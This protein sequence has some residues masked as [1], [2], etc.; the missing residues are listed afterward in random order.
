MTTVIHRKTIALILAVLLEPVC[1]G[2]AQDANR[3]WGAIAI[4]CPPIF[5]GC[6]G[7]T[8]GG[9]YG[10]TRTLARKAAISDCV[11]GDI[12]LTEARYCKIVRAFNRGCAYVVAGC[13]KDSSVC[14]YALGATEA[15]AAKRCA[16]EG[17][18]C[19]IPQFGVGGCVGK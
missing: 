16:R 14:G 1:P 9:G 8:G 18:D 13:K 15:E 2:R 19:S 17:F 11:N 3:T 4:F 10:R 6:K 12:K 5:G 7:I